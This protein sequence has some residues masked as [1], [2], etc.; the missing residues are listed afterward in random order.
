MQRPVMNPT[1]MFEQPAKPKPKRQYLALVWR[2]IRFL[3]R[4]LLSVPFGRK[5]AA[6]RNEE[7]TRF[8]RFM[9]ALTY[10]LA[11]VPVVL[12]IFLTAM[13]LSAT[14]PRL[15]MQGTDPLAIGVYYDPVN[16]LA[17]DGARLDGWLVPVIDAKRVLEEKEQVIG[18]RYPAVVLVHDFDRSREQLLPLVGP[19]HDAQMVVLA[20]NLRGAAAQSREAQTFGLRE[21]KDVKAAVDMLRRRNFVD[22]Q[23]I[24]LIGVGSGANACVIAAKSDPTLAAMVL[25]DPAENFDEAF[26]ARIGEDHF[27]LPALQPLLRWTFQV[28]YGVDTGE[29]EIAGHKNIIAQKHVLM[30]DSRQNLTQPNSMR[31]VK[32]FLQKHLDEQLATAK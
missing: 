13:V 1:F 29:L 26:A 22:P 21:A 24:A 7:G 5:A 17:E 27:W 9:R 30:T 28:M 19:L 25:A 23:K 12:V 10:R 11:F 20:I 14:H 4:L 31:A 8:S 15:S 16:F 6:F 18:K 2:L 32:R 3:F